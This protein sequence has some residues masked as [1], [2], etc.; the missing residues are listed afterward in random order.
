MVLGSDNL[1]YMQDNIKIPNLPYMVPNSSEVDS[2]RT[3]PKYDVGEIKVY[4]NRKYRRIKRGSSNL[5]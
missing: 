4:G 2:K 5:G 1:K 3:Y